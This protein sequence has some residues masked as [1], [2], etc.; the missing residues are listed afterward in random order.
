M[1]FIVPQSRKNIINLMQYS[2]KHR[3]R[4]G[5]RE[6]IEEYIVYIEKDDGRGEVVAEYDAEEDCLSAIND[7]ANTISYAESG[8]DIIFE[9]PPRERIVRA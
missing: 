9:M 8:T 4:G 3:Q 1:V 7:F 5:K 2:M 6:R